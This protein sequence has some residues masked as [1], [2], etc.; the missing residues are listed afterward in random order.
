MNFSGVAQGYLNYEAQQKADAQQAQEQ[1]FRAQQMQMQALQIENARTAQAKIENIDQQASWLAPGAAQPP[2]QPPAPGQASVPMQPPPA[3]GQMAPQAGPPQ[4]QPMPQP[5]MQQAGAQAM[6]APQSIPPYQS[7]AKMQAPQG[8]PA[9][10]ASQM[11]QSPAAPQAG[12]GMPTAP[13]QAPAQGAQQSQ[14]QGVQAP[15]VQQIQTQQIM[16][17]LTQMASADPLVDMVAQYRQQFAD[18][19]HPMS[20]I[21]VTN[22]ILNN[23]AA[24]FQYQNAL[25]KNKFAAETLEKVQTAAQNALRDAELDARGNKQISQTGAA[26]VETARHNRQE[27]NLRGQ[28]ISVERQKASAAANSGTAY[29]LLPDKQKKAIDYYAEM[30]LRGDQSWRTGLGRT[31]GGSNLIKQVDM[32]VPE[33]ASERGQTV[34]DN[35]ANKAIQKSLAS[36]LTDRTKYLATAN[37]FSRTMDSQIAIVNKYMGKGVAGSKPVFNEWIEHGRKALAGDKD[38]TALDNAIRGMAREHQKFVTGVT[39]NAQLYAS[40][41][42]T[43]DD[44]MNIAQTEDQMKIAMQEMSE[45][46]E[47]AIKAG[48]EEVSEL[49]NQIRDL[50]KPSDSRAAASNKVTGISSKQELQSAISSGKLKKGDTFTDS[51]GQAHVVQ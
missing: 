45:E 10:G 20:D 29:D 44:M 31:S 11:G 47:G 26:Q 37:Q 13:G 43:A 23:P 34:G 25:A 18:S 49:Q 21:A 35:I 30:S 1:A 27:E 36:T 6:P 24:N 38:V 51:N 42:K 2:P 32:R 22:F 48:R 15:G 33:L 46:K 3:P 16:Q 14:D 5:P 12:G 50:G 40:A 39:S 7:M 17:K 19:G 41:Q 8:M 28:E 4:G 9:P